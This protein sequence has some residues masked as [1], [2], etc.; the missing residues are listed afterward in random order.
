[1][2]S[3]AYARWVREY[4][5]CENGVHVFQPEGGEFG[6]ITLENF[7]GETLA[8][9]REHSTAGDGDDWDL[10]CDLVKNGDIIEDVCIRRQDLEIIRRTLSTK[11]P[12]HD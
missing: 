12:P 10:I 3:L 6:G 11:A 9:F 5:P 4:H 2:D 8:V 7:P 1:M